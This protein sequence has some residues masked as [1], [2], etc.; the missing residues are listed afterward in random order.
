MLSPFS[1]SWVLDRLQSYWTCTVELPVQKDLDLLYRDLHNI[2]DLVPQLLYVTRYKYH[3]PV[4]TY[5]SWGETEAKSKLQS[6]FRSQ[7]TNFLKQQTAYKYNITKPQHNSKVFLKPFIVAFFAFHFWCYSDIQAVS[8]CHTSPQFLYS[9]YHL[10][11][12]KGFKLQIFPLIPPLEHYI[13]LYSAPAT[14][15]S[16]LSCL[17]PEP[18]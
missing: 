1:D 14:F 16:T 11:Y 5:N 13:V 7:S 3:W 9:G 15:L 10:L 17:C 6:Q 18:F 2:Q 8:V 4:H 12:Q